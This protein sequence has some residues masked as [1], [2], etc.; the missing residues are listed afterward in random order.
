MPNDNI[1][2]LDPNQIIRL[3][4]GRKYFG[5]G[6]TQLDLKIKSGEVPKPLA[7]SDTGHAKGW[8]GSQIIAHQRRLLEAAAKAETSRPASKRKRA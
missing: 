7:L 3:R 1:S 6:P 8:L 2:E 5:F 4:H